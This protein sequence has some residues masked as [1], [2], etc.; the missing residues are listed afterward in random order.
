VSRA[1]SSPRS[2]VLKPENH[3][4]GACRPRRPLAFLC[5]IHRHNLD[6]NNQSRRFAT[7]TSLAPSSR[8]KGAAAGAGLRTKVS[9]LSTSSQELHWKVRYSNPGPRT[10]SPGSAPTKFISVPHSMHNMTTRPSARSER[11]VI[12]G[13]VSERTVIG[14]LHGCQSEEAA[15]P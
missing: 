6:C 5:P 9:R 15:R 14:N 13:L 8:G 2:S 10:A 3:P 4:S 7:E 12:S 1:Q 11:P